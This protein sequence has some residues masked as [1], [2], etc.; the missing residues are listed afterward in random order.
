MLLSLV[1][2]HLL[3]NFPQNKLLAFW[4]I[5]IKSQIFWHKGQ[6]SIIEKGL[7]V[8]PFSPEGKYAILY[9]VF[10]VCN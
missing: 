3:P 4:I 2:V 10:C 9:L 5:T 6:E 8:P 1:K 7:S